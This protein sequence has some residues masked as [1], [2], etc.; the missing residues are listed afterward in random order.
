M[1]AY[2]NEI[3]PYA[4]QWLRNL[5]AAGHIA[6]GDVDE[7]SIEDVTPD[8]IRNYTQCHFFAGI[9]VW[10]YALRRA[11]WPDD[12]PVW[13]G[14]CPCQPFSAA[15]QGGGF[16]DERHLWPHFHYLI[17]QCRPPVVLVSKL[18]AKTAL[19]GSTLYKLTWKERTTPQQLSIFALRASVLRISDSASTGWPTP[20]TRDWKDT[21]DLDKGRIRKDGKERNDTLG[22]QAWLAGWPT[23]QVSM[24][25]N[26]TTVQMS[27]DGRTTPNKL[28][29][30]AA[31]TTP[32]R[33]AASGEILTGLAAEMESG[34]QLNP[35]HSRWL[36]ALPPEWDDCAPTEMPSAR[37]SQKRL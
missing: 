30:A 18:Q 6:A 24:I 4:A 12:K 21:G 17:E 26:A 3:D 11:G 23:P 1:A 2:Y 25:T 7:R 29:W 31:I 14:S 16:D 9:G 19:A 27:S 33:L 22:R 35:A 8:D 10:S 36:M 13:T 34:G 37:K 20:T 32:H 28:G 15:G 5:V